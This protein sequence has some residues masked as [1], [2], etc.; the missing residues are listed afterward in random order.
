MNIFLEII[1]ISEFFPLEAYFI[2]YLILLLV[3]TR[4]ILYS[5]FFFLVGIQ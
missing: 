4:Y 5:E 3:V 1:N 2:S